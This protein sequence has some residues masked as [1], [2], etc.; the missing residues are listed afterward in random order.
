M[1][2]PG[3]THEVELTRWP[4]GTVSDSLAHLACA[5]ASCLAE[6]CAACTGAT[7]H[8]WLLKCGWL[9]LRCAVNIEYTG[10]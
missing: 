2:M 8:V 4:K 10:V 1:A 7:S 9:N 6:G 3:V 5:V